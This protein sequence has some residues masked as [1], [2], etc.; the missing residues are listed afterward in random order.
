MV[1]IHD[2]EGPHLLHHAHMDN[3]FI[4]FGIYKCE[5]LV[6]LKSHCNKS[7]AATNF[8]TFFSFFTLDFVC[9]LLTER[10]RGCYA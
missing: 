1:L 8:G 9:D 7:A 3:Q 10:H 2:L 6:K 4:Q 5:K